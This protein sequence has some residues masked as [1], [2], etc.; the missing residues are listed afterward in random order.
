MAGE[1][2][3]VQLALLGQQMTQITAA[4]AKLENLPTTVHDLGLKV[5]GLDN[6]LTEQKPTIDEFI[7]IKH[8]V[9]GAG[10]L[11]RWLWLALAFLLGLVVSARE[12]IFPH[13]LGAR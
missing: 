6:R 13:L 11:G 3:E 5:Q 2:T 1:S 8:K 10:M 7:T 9:V 4:L 12:S